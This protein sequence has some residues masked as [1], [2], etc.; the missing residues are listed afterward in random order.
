MTEKE[1]SHSRLLTVAEVAERLSLKP[2]TIRK[3]ILQRRI[4][5][6][7]PSIRA[8]RIPESAVRRILGKGYTEAI[9]GANEGQP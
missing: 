3:M 8:V 7:R 1:L 4:D 9:P 6:I 2:A 5:V